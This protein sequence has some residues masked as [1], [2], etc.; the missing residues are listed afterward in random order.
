VQGL[1]PS[2][3]LVGLCTASFI[4]YYA[5]TADRASR[6]L[7]GR[8][9]ENR[10]VAGFGI[11]SYS[12]YLTHQILLYGFDLVIRKKLTGNLELLALIACL[13]VVVGFSYLFYLAFEKRFATSSRSPL[14]PATAVIVNTITS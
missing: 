2:D 14:V 12:F 5:L 7:L 11:I 3:F 8:I 9:L 4:V 1:W 13:P 10:Y 6:S